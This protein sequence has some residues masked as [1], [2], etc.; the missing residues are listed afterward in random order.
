[1]TIGLL[2][3]MLGKKKEKKKNFS[4]NLHYQRFAGRKTEKTDE[5]LD[6]NQ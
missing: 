1:V 3:V 5:K 4:K 2:H 6:Q